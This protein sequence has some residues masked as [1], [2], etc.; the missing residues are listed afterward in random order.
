METV[1]IDGEKIKF[2]KGALRKQMKLKNGEEFTRA[3]LN[4]LKKVEVGKSFK[5]F[6]RTYKMTKLMKKR[7]TFASVLMKGNKKK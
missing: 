2:K 5:A 7:I 4:K 3:M 1:N 6:N